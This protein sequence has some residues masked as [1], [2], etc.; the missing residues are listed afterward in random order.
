MLFR[1]ATTKDVPEIMKVRLSV[2][3]NRLSDPSRVTAEICVEYLTDIGRG[4]VCEVD[5][6]VV[7][8]SIASR[9]DASIWA[10]FVLPEFEG[11]GIG[12]SLL[13]L[14]VDWLFDEGAYEISLSTDPQTR[15]DR[16]YLAQGWIRSDILPNGEV[17]YRLRKNP[18]DSV[19]PARAD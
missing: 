7:G 12:R 9:V 17:Q 11:R 18:S 8:F 16:F 2:R 4:W 19:S 14:A 1:E 3:E 13:E 15:A 6:R 5:G 10:L